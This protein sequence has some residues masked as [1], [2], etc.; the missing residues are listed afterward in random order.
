MEEME[1]SILHWLQN[2]VQYVTEET[3]EKPSLC[4]LHVNK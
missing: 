1:A 3:L 2:V 4:D